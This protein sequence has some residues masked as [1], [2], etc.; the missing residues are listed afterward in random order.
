MLRRGLSSSLLLFDGVSFLKAP[1]HLST[2][3]GNTAPHKSVEANLLVDIIHTL[4]I[5]L[6][7]S[8]ASEDDIH[9][10]E[11]KA[12]RLWYD[13]PDKGRADEGQ[14]AEDEIGAFERLVK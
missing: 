11:R 8:L 14:D 7:H 12:L 6:S 3:A 5:C 4:Y 13:E 1:V 9:L 10:L 2:A